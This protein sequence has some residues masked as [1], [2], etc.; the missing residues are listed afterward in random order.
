MGNTNSE[1]QIKGDIT[2]EEIFL[3]QAEL[4]ADI[5]RRTFSKQSKILS[6]NEYNCPNY[7]AFETADKINCKLINDEHIFLLRVNGTAL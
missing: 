1:V 4:I 2:I 7:V 5:I 6:L 3:G